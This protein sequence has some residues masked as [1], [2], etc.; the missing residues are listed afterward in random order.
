MEGGIDCNKFWLLQHR[1][2][3]R[4][5]RNGYTLFWR[6][7]DLND[8][9]ISFVGFFCFFLGGKK[10]KKSRHSFNDNHGM[11]RCHE[12][13]RSDMIGD[14][15]LLSCICDSAHISS[16]SENVQGMYQSQLS[17]PVSKKTS[18]IV[19]RKSSECLIARS[20]ISNSMALMCRSP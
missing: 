14:W 12:C 13:L 20:S 16:S 9:G 7:S 1:Y 8:Y 5:L 4:A 18:R 3:T 2:F 17:V 19:L 11:K 6:L 10:E 15:V